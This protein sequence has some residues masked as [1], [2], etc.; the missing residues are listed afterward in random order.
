MSGQPKLKELVNALEDLT[1]DEVRYLCIKLG[2]CQRTLDKIDSDNATVLTRIPKY[3]ESWLD[4]DSQPSWEKLTEALNSKKLNKSVLAKKI[5]EK[6]CPM[7]CR[8][9][10]SP[11][12]SRFS[13]AASSPHVSQS[14]NISSSS[15]SRE[16]DASCTHMAFEP[17]VATAAPSKL[18][19]EEPRLRR[20]VFADDLVE[21]FRSVV[22]S[23]NVHLTQKDMPPSEF[24]Y[25]KIDLTNLPMHLEKYTFSTKKEAKD[26]T[27]KVYARGI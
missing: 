18:E 20:E 7:A 13:D 6:Y 11:S 9:K 23:A 4:R 10:A 25:F 5:T 21:R 1:A 27:S 19:S 3:L 15:I 16:D 12:L 26:Y 2:V 14:S 24:Y 17:P 22:I 8:S